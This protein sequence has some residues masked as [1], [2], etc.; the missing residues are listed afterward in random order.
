MEKL[1][2]DAEMLKKEK[3]KPMSFSCLIKC[4]KNLEMNDIF[5]LKIL[6]LRTIFIY[7]EKYC[8]VNSFSINIHT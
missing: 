8:I 4:T 3:D 6:L 5:K 2:D 1:I 7:F